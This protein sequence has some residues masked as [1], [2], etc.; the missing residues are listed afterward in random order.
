MG[1]LVYGKERLERH[2]NA[3]GLKMLFMA[4]DCSDNT[5]KYWHN[6]TNT[7]NTKLI[8]FRFT[9]KKELAKRLGKI[10][11]SAVSTTNQDILKGIM[12]LLEK[13]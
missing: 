1:K 9:T 5:K 6:K 11:L 12:R 4:S 13:D 3:S 10:E 8:L 7:T 2:L